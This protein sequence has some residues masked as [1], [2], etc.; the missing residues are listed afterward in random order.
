MSNL[1]TGGTDHFDKCIIVG[2]NTLS[3][4]AYGKHNSMHGKKHSSHNSYEER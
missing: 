2:S 4:L 3:Q 1:H